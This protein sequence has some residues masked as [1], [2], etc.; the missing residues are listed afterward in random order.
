MAEFLKQAIDARVIQEA[1]YATQ[2]TRELGVFLGEDDAVNKR[3][4]LEWHVTESGTRNRQHTSLEWMTAEKA[5]NAPCYEPEVDLKK[6]ILQD[7]AQRQ[8][9]KFDGFVRSLRL[10]LGGMLGRPLEE[11]KPTDTTAWYN[12]GTSANRTANQM[13]DKFN[14]GDGFTIEVRMD[15]L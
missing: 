5:E 15:K 11:V 14:C 12:F 8:E 2:I 9:A 3:P 10:L 4:T 1:G 13:S 7:Q 6:L